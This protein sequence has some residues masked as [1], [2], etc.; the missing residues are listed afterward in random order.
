MT[1][2]RKVLLWIAVVFAVLV[3]AAIV[4]LRMPAFGGVA[5]GA[6]LERMRHSPQFRGKRFQNP[7]PQKDEFEYLTTLRNYRKNQVR[8]P[9]FVVP[10]VKLAASQFTG[11][12]R[13]GL[14]AYWIG[15]STALIEIDGIRV[16]TDPVFSDYVSPFQGIGP[17]RLHT[18]PLALHQ[19]PSLDAVLISHDHFDHLDMAAIKFFAARGTHFYVPLGIGAHLQRWNVPAGQVHEMDW[20]ESASINGV[21]VNCTPARHYSGRK[22]ADNSTLWSAWLVRGPHTSFYY[23]GD[24]GY[25]PHFSETRKR[26]GGVDLA[27]IKI[28]AYGDTWLDI[29]MD[30]ESAIQAHK[31]LGAKIFLPV[32]WATFNLSYHAWDEPILRTLAAAHNANVQ[33]ITPAPGEEFEFGK[34]FENREWYL[35]H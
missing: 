18:L 35:K 24:T 26:L 31:D 25:S 29:H 2:R 7:P 20:W 11:D 27:L 12:I 21:Q 14:R 8:A 15:H 33:V 17:K 10:I 16:I 34:P 9:E 4:T 30:T 23:S 22:R 19:I 3:I 5:E 28:G 32:H 13:P 1:T 6:R